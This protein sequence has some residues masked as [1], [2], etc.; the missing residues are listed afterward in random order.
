MIKYLYIFLRLADVP[1]DDP[2]ILIGPVLAC[3][4][5]LVLVYLPMFQVT[6]L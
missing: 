4:G 2:L 6:I 5:V 1:G 3:C